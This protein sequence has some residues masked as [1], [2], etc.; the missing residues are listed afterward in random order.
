MHG[1]PAKL[2]QTHAVINFLSRSYLLF[3]FV[4]IPGSYCKSQFVAFL[5]KDDFILFPVLHDHA[6][7]KS[8]SVRNRLAFYGTH[9][10]LAS[11]ILS[12]SHCFLSFGCK[13]LFTN[14]LHLQ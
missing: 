2:S 11:A 13:T 1:P 6:E 10:V 7:E 9:S 3:V 5:S 14:G 12:D 4:H 8:L